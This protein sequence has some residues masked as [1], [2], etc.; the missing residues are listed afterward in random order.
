MKKLF[1]IM[2]MVFLSFNTFAEL[3]ANFFPESNPIFFNPSVDFSTGTLD[4]S[5]GSNLGNLITSEIR[6]IHSD[7]GVLDLNTQTGLGSRIAITTYSYDLTNLG[8]YN[9]DYTLEI[10]LINEDNPSLTNV[11]TE[12][13]F[14][15]S[16]GVDFVSQDSSNNFGVLNTTISEM[17]LVIAVL[18]SEVTDLLTGDL[19]VLAIVGSLIAFIIG[20]ITLL[21]TYLRNITNSSMKK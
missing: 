6:L 20:L 8:N 15:Y 1:L 3:T 9:G 2:M 11:N 12:N 10:T 19:I 7:L 16:N 21:L 18:V 17:F 5:V 14:T 13:I 4:F